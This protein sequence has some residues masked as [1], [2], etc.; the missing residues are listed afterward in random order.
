[1]GLSYEDEL[2]QRKRRE[3]RDRLTKAQEKKSQKGYQINEYGEIIRGDYEK[4][5]NKNLQG[6]SYFQILEKIDEAVK[7]REAQDR[8]VWGMVKTLLCA[9]VASVLSILIAPSWF[10]PMYNSSNWVFY[11]ALILS[12]LNTVKD[13]GKWLMFQEERENRFFETSKNKFKIHI[14][15]WLILFLVMLIGGRVDLSI[16]YNMGVFLY[17]LCIMF[18]YMKSYLISR[19]IRNN[20]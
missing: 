6:E 8:K 18:V 7:K 3:L 12:I 11:V 17:I 1:M 4:L 5:P 9:D 10:S 16:N 14:A 20:V 19:Y 15:I 13:Y 2:L